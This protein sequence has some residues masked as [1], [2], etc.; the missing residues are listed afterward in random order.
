MQ[1]QNVLTD[2]GFQKCSWD[3]AVISTIESCLLPESSKIVFQPYTLRTE[4][5]PDSLNVLMILCT[6]D[7][8]I[9]KFFAEVHNLFTSSTTEVQWNY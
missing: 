2:N 1:Q 9:P 4:I 7:D 3:H 8:E 6:I 5:T